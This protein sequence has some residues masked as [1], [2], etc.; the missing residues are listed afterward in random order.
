VLTAIKEQSG[1]VFIY[2]D[3]DI[4][5]ARPVSIE[6]KNATVEQA[7]REVF[8]DQPLTYEIKGT[9]VVIKEKKSLSPQVTEG[10]NPR[11]E[12]APPPANID[13]TVMVIGADNNQG[14]EGA[15]VMIK[16]SNKG[17][18]TD[19]N[20][21]ATLK[22]VDPNA[23]VVISFTGYMSQEI[24]VSGINPS[25]IVVKL[26]VST[27]E[28]QEVVI[29]KGYYTEKQKLSTGNV[30]TVKASD[31]QKQPV[32][33]PLLTLT[34]HVP[35][36]EIT[37]SNGVPGSAISVKIR[38]QNSFS[39]GTDPLYVIDGV[40]YSSQLLPG[41]G[42]ML[43]RAGQNLNGGVQIYGNPLSFINT[44]E[45]ESIDVLKDA[46]AT[47]IYGSRAAN[48]AILITTK[49]GK[50]GKTKGDINAY[51]GWGRVPKMLD[52]LNTRQ[53]L[54]M[55]YEAFKNDGATP[56]SSAF[57]ITLWDTTRY[58]DWQKLLIG[59]T[60]HYNDIQA[61]VSG[62]NAQTQ[63]LIGTGY[64][65]QSTVFPSE[66]G[67]RK[68]SVHFN[69]NSSSSNQKFNILLTGS[70]LSDDNRLFSEDPTKYTRLAPDAPAVYNNDGSLNW[71]PRP[72]NGR[73]S[74]ANPLSYTKAPYKN[75]TNNL[76]ASASISYNISKAL[77]IKSSFGY[78]HMESNEIQATPFAYW[79]PWL[80]PF[81][82][83]ASRFANN[84]STSW[85][86][87]PQLTYKTK[88]SKGELN[89]LL[90]TTIQKNNREGTLL[91]ASG[92]ANDGLIENIKA[93]SSITVDNY[94][95]TVY[96]Y[97]AGFGRLNY[98]WQDKYLINLTA[99]RDGSSRFGP[100]NRFHN[101]G[102]AGVGW[103]FSNEK[104]IKSNSSFLSYG[105]LR[106]SYGTTGNDQIGDYRYLDRYFPTNLTYQG[107]T[108]LTINNLFNP[109]LAW[110]ET[111][112][113][114]GGL[115]LGFLSDRIYLTVS[116]FKNRSSNQLSGYSLASTT[117]FP[118]VAANLDATIQNK[119]WEFLI[120]SRNIVT[121][122][123]TWS[124]SFNLTTY[125]NKVIS[126]GPTALGID[127][128]ILGHSLNSNYI[129]PFL[130]VDPTTGNYRFLS[131]HGTPIFSPDTTFFK[132]DLNPSF[133]GGLQNSLQY[134]GFQF[135]LFFQFVKQ[136][137]Q[138]VLYNPLF[139]PGPSG[140][141][142]N[143]PVSM[144]DRWQK[145]G[146]IRPIQKYSQNFGNFSSFDNASNSD[147]AYSDASFIRLKNLSISYTLPDNIR[148]KIGVQNLRVYVQ[149]Q[150]LFTITKYKGLDP[151]TKSFATL[152]T[153]RIITTGIQMT[154]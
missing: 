22:G 55:R 37:Q 89:V 20:G 63:Y 19:V 116:Y 76:I 95:Q 143:V 146:D 48:G 109:A 113:L 98:N 5:K 58:T 148:N 6:L 119:G 91:S 13:V 62:G 30:S 147:A 112:K 150:N 66:S 60:A 31:I 132:D 3:K 136:I 129:H 87:E 138:N 100:D 90:G 111:K 108:G 69:I 28:L 80:W 81:V 99:R 50:S 67:D 128:G 47:A 79:D 16:G 137:A 29:N 73:G 75:L 106:G 40:P 4:A 7:L 92:F 97:N 82:T 86:I 78:T 43:G 103:I 59:N 32:D 117:G 1:Y 121:S 114:E 122:K 27:S 96:K 153:L 120:N 145:P 133:Y 54:D 154:F 140:S 26:V 42:L 84:T 94:E 152:P 70:Y 34:A 118:N 123:L 101:F 41:L 2:N 144:L 141:A 11:L 45:I 12:T 77:Q 135:D 35:G 124:T 51:T 68:A 74:W 33:N 107:L 21:R 8:R 149:C 44:S 46:D 49:K 130:D 104:F 71:A 72:S 134:K 15:S 36:L 131:T 53:Y 142:P 38:G 18:V 115:E 10:L 110:E 17:V 105:K 83:P 151:E 64:Q 93:A 14:L 65:M 24:K 139:Y 39:N 102:A 126:I 85:I 88:I 52:L 127:N 23:T 57:D 9:S 56:S 61:S 25:A 125:K